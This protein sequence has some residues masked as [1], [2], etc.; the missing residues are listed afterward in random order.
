MNRLQ[1]K[2]LIVTA[3]FHLLLVLTLVFGSA[4]FTQRTKTD[5][6]Q[7]LDVIPANLVEAAFNSGV[8]NA[9]PPAP[10]PV[11]QIPIV[12]PPAPL[13]KPQPQPEPP[14]P[15]PVVTPPEPKPEPV[16]QPEPVKH[17]RPDPEVAKT[18]EPE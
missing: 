1:K 11:E 9:Q 4:F 3:G 14:K 12:Q 16:K 10:R 5:D 17:T 18:A 2:C 8:K 15:K 6:T 13:P 7:V